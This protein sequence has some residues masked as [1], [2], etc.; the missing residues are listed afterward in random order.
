[1]CNYTRTAVIV[2]AHHVLH[3]KPAI[4]EF[5]VNVLLMHKA[6][7]D[8]WPQIGKGDRNTI[9]DALSETTD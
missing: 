6:G 5:G 2:Y 3:I 7:T 9:S 1:M 8:I 4:T